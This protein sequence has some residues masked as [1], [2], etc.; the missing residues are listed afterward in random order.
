[1]ELK[2]ILAEKAKSFPY[3]NIIVDENGKYTYS[4]F[5]L[6][7]EENLNYLKKHLSSSDLV[8][9]RLPRNKDYVLSM[10]A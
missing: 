3:K 1:M 6:E 9:L 7:L 2:R 8:L 5:Y 4:E 10:I